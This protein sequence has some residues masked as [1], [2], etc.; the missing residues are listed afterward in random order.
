MAPRLV[1]RRPVCG[2]GAVAHG[3]YMRH[4]APVSAP[5]TK[6]FRREPRL[7]AKTRASPKGCSQNRRRTAARSRDRRN[8]EQGPRLWG[9]DR[10]ADHGR[11]FADPNARLRGRIQAQY[12]WNLLRPPRDGRVARLGNRMTI[13][14]AGRLALTNSDCNAHVFHFVMDSLGM[15]RVLQLVILNQP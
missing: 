15:I 6:P 12:A 13:A 8:A 4:L 2:N 11:S 10:G 3:M 14:C 5:T 1:S 7:Q 9:C